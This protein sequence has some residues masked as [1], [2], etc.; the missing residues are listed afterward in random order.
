[1]NTVTLP[2][3]QNPAWGFWGTMKDQAAEAWPLAVQIL[4]A[5]TGQSP[6]AARAF[7]D[8]RHG[9]HF[10]DNVSSEILASASLREAIETVALRLMSMTISPRI[11]RD[12]GIPLGLPYLTG[13]VLSCEIA[14]ADSDE[15]TPSGTKAA[16]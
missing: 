14:E 2:E 13:I 16:P 5:K 8:S 11:S 3:T 6:E 9:R 12:F 4:C 7:L 15:H 1:M 10:A